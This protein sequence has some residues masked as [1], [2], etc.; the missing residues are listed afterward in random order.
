MIFKR[1]GGVEYGEWRL[2]TMLES[3][4]YEQ[5][6]W[7]SMKVD[8]TDY[9]PEF[10]NY[11]LESGKRRKRNNRL[12]ALALLALAALMVLSFSLFPLIQQLGHK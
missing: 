9:M 5:I 11:D 10:D 8:E 7:N 12:V 4:E 3:D 1:L 2:Y 6:N